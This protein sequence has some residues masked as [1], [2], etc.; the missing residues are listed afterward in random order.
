[1][2]DERESSF[3]PRSSGGATRAALATKATGDGEEDMA[4]SAAAAV[5]SPSSGGGGGGGVKSLDV[6]DNF[7]LQEERA[8]VV[9]VRQSGGDVD[10]RG[11]EGEGREGGEE[12]NGVALTGDGG[13]EGGMNGVVREENEAAAAAG[14]L[15]GAG[16]TPAM[17]PVGKA[18]VV[19]AKVQHPSLSPSP[20][21]AKTSSY[22]S[23]DEEEDG[24]GDDVDDDYYGDD[25]DYDDGDVDNHGYDDCDGHDDNHHHG[26]DDVPEE[27]QQQPVKQIVRVP[28]RLF[29]VLHRRL[30]KSR[31]YLASPYR[32]EV[33]GW[34]CGVCCCFCSSC[35]FCFRIVFFC[36]A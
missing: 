28:V 8:E 21:R 25:E 32:L 14:F 12:V 31:S 36:V 33:G 18:V 15:R 29:A 19:K 3:G 35:I 22:D 24:V 23:R 16:G 13:G 30:E 5:I 1:M 7:T 10:D 26:Y 4:S 27:Q 2:V 34:V 17:V 9:G 6:R 20:P 11:E